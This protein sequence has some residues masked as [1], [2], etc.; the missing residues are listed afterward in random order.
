MSH[1]YAIN[2]RGYYDKS[3]AQI[4]AYFYPTL[5]WYKPDDASKII[6]S[7][8]Q[9][10]FDITEIHARK[11]RKRIAEF[12]FTQNSQTESKALYETTEKE[13]R[14]MQERFDIDTRHSRDVQQEFVWESKIARMLDELDDYSI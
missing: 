12:E 3:S 9:A 8:E 10:H 1:S 14:A 6:L 13:R 2:H 4:Y 5:S 11:L 7:H